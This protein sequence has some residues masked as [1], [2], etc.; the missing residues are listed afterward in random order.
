MKLLFKFF[1][2]I[3]IISC[4]KEH[5]PLWY[6]WAFIGGITQNDLYDI[7]IIDSLNG[8]AVGD[9]GVILK[10]KD[11][12][13]KMDVESLFPIGSSETYLSTVWALDTN[14]VWAGGTGLLIN[15]DGIIWRKIFEGDFVIEDMEFISK[16][17]GWAVGRKY[18][19][20]QWCNPYI[21]K[22]ENGK[23]NEVEI[24]GEGY[25]LWCVNLVS[26]D[27][28][29]ITGGTYSN[30][31]SIRCY[32]GKWEKFVVPYGF[33]IYNTSFISPNNG[34]GVDWDGVVMKFEDGWKFLDSLD[35]P[36]WNIKF[37]SKHDGIVV[38]D[39][40]FQYRDGWRDVRFKSTFYGISWLDINNI[41]LCGMAGILVFGIPVEL[42]G[43]WYKYK[44]ESDREMVIR[45]IRE[46]KR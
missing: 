12:I 13:W 16:D 11:G 32:K 36:L 30:P 5:L 3:T 37:I 15:Y 33:S 25:G 22:Y 41:W 14:D 4:S 38:G 2:I 26:K 10:M 44:G 35:T 1:L 34:W 40:I 28:I 42:E 46:E 18:W 7:S 6:E 19:F 23:W 45:E 31:V 43:D 20:K 8:Y 9:D 29:W 21:L 27:C 17:Y 24:I 39:R